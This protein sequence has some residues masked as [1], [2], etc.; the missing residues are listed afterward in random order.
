MAISG[1]C[2]IGDRVIF[3]GRAGSSDNLTFGDDA[4]LGGTSVAW[5]DVPAGASLWGNPA[6]E[7]MLELRI[8][9]ALARLP[10]MQKSLRAMTRADSSAPTA[11]QK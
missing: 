3:A 6:R 11:G 7:K 1:S 5:K 2:R 4:V 8:Q 10:E 9:S